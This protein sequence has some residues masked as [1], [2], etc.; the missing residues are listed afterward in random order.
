MRS[1]HPACSLRTFMT[2]GPVPL[3]EYILGDKRQKRRQKKM[4]KE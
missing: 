4:K 2:S 1:R 3:V